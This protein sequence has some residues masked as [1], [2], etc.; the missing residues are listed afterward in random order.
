M[1][2]QE[3]KALVAGEKVELAIDRRIFPHAP[4][5]T[6]ALQDIGFDRMFDLVLH[7]SDDSPGATHYP[8][9]EHGRLDP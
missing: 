6:I 9:E 2:E 3:F 4:K 7:A 5:I 1:D 8:R